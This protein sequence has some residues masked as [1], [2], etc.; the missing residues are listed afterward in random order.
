[1]SKEAKNKSSNNSNPLSPEEID[2]LAQKIQEDLFGSE[3]IFKKV[4]K[5]TSSVISSIA[6]G[7]KKVFQSIWEGIKKVAE[8][9][10]YPFVSIKKKVEGVEDGTWYRFMGGIIGG[11]LGFILGAAFPEAVILFSLTF[12]A[13]MSIK[14]MFSDVY[15]LSDASQTAAT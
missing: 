8:V 12:T 13:F 10:I 3:G 11:G 6:G 4:I 5:G 7:I 9:I 15:S 2:L 1:M 14:L